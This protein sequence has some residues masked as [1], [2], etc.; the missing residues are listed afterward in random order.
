LVDVNRAQRHLRDRFGRRHV[1]GRDL[2]HRAVRVPD[3]DGVGVP[4][5]QYADQ[6]GQTARYP[7]PDDDTVADITGAEA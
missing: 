3:G 7:V 4:S 1:R 6:V 5:L 2:V